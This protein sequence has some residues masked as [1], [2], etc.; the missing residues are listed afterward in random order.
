MVPNV[1]AQSQPA[2]AEL[3]HAALERIEAGDSQD[4]FRQ[5]ERL[6]NSFPRD[7]ELATAIGTAQDAQSRPEDAAKWYERALAI[8]PNYE[9]ALNNL[10]LAYAN[11]GNLRGGFVLLQKVVRMD[12]GNGGAAF[13]LGL[14]ALSLKHYPESVKAFRLAREAPTLAAPLQKILLGEGTA[15]FHMGKYRQ[16]ASSLRGASA[17]SE[18]DTCL[19]LGSSQALSDDLPA[20]VG[21]FQAAVH[22]APKNPEPY[23]SLAMALSEGGRDSE[24][25]EALEHGLTVAPASPVL[26]FG[27]AVI[28]RSEGNFDQAVAL[29]LRSLEGE[30]TDARVWALLGTLRTYQ[31]QIAEAEKAFLNALRFGAG[32]ETAVEYAELLIQDERYPEAENRLNEMHKTYPNRAAVDRGLGKLYKAEQ[33]WDKAEV[34]LRRSAFEDRNDPA[35]HY[36]LAMTLEHLH[37]PAE[38]RQEMSLFKGT[39]NKRRF[40]RALEVDSASTAMNGR[41][42]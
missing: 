14:M 7:P 22:M 10:A 26:L 24:A 9:P 42:K 41:G 17:C 19:L 2:W 34:F 3:C 38:A 8:D 37:R 21:T 1:S 40:V 5:L 35:V 27:Q 20:A 6:G 32:V 16:A 18:L 11:Q 13:N 4:G 12:P 15:L 30:P 28:C 23:F 29:A 33:R 31:G 25:K 39:K 36:A